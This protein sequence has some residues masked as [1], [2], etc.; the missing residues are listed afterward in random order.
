[1]KYNKYVIPPLAAVFVLII[2][3]AYSLF[4]QPPDSQAGRQA[5]DAAEPELRIAAASDPAPPKAAD[6]E[7]TVL[8]VPWPGEPTSPSIFLLSQEL[9]ILKRHGLDFE[10]AGVIPSPQLVAAV[11]SGQIDVSHGAHINRTIAG[12][13]A[14]AKVLA[15]VGNTE[16][17]QRVPHMIALVTKQS[18]IKEPK[19][20]IGKKIG[21]PTIGGCN[22]YT[23]YAWMDLHGIADAKSKVE[24]T[25]VPEK[26]LEQALRQGEIDLAM[27]HK[28]PEEVIRAGEFNIV[29]SDYDVWGDAGGATPPYFGVKYI[30]EH[31]ATVRS[32]TAAIAETLNWANAHPQEAKELTAKR[33]GMDVNLLAERYFT[34]DGIIKPKTAQVWIDLLTDF[35]EIKPGITL[36]EIYTNEFNPFYKPGA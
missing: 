2:Y 25:V 20:L 18:P 9:G 21:I 33:V 16:T 6:P 1:M 15:V 36:P 27:M 14:G 32:F 24:V 8:R 22:E 29:F 19:D 28:V 12:I 17:S 10:F 23:P 30:Q 3:A 5:P 13:S 11:V 4:S 34:P 7:L 35:G 26:N 31:P